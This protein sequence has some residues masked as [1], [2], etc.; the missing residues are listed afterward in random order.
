MEGSLAL[1]KGWYA[2]AGRKQPYS[3]GL[4]EPS[5]RP[6]GVYKTAQQSRPRL[7]GWSLRGCSAC[8]GF[9]SHTVRLAARCRGFK[10]A[11]VPKRL[12][13]S[14]G[15]MQVAGQRCM[16]LCAPDVDGSRVVLTGEQQ[17]GGTV[18][19]SDHILRHEVLLGAAGT[20][21]GA[22]VQLPDSTSTAWRTHLMQGMLAAHCT[23]NA[24]HSAAHM[25][26]PGRPH[27][28]T[29]LP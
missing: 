6:E 22:H 4:A 23:Q 16:Q 12:L 14:E 21:E 24:L 3:I 19:P 20:G 9:A 13:C 17:L 27:A 2:E 5:V 29:S 7:A 8:E 10:E 1:H 25:C 28:A 15:W 11:A 26:Q 18:P